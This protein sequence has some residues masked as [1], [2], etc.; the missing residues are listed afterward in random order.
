[1]YRNGTV[2]DL[3]VKKNTDRREN[4]NVR[5]YPSFDGLTKENLTLTYG[6][7]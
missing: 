3:P 7:I 4:P 2:Y 1:M 5:I 6:Q